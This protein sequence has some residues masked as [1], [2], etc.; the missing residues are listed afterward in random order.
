MNDS[1]CATTLFETEFWKCLALL[2]ERA[3]Q[4]LYLLK[5]KR[6]KQKQTDREREIEIA[7]TKI[8]IKLHG[9]WVFI[10]VSI[11]HIIY[12]TIAFVNQTKEICIWKERR[13][14]PIKLEWWHEFISNWKEL[15]WIYQNYYWY[16]WNKLRNTYVANKTYTDEIQLC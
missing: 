14:R 6:G 1:M 3:S 8:D 16:R 7:S 9:K 13:I 5:K 12:D 11:R 2:S 15:N 10:I 4:Q